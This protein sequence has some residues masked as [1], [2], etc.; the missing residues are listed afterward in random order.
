MAYD[1]EAF[2]AQRMKTTFINDLWFWF[3]VHNVDRSNSLMD[4]LTWFGGCFSCFLI[5]FPFCFP[6]GSFLI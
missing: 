5:G 6:I 4:F 2:F 1:N 3:N